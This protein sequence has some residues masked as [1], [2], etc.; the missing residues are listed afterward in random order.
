MREL[1]PWRGTPRLL[2]PAPVVARCRQLRQ[3]G[4]WRAA[5]AAAGFQVDIDLDDVAARYDVEAR[6]RIEDELAALAPD[7][8]RQYLTFEDLEY[9][10]NHVLSPSAT[11]YTWSWTEPALM[12]TNPRPPNGRRRPR[13]TVIGPSELPTHVTC[14][15]WMWRADAM[16]ERRDAYAVGAEWTTKDLQPHRRGELSRHDLHPLVHDA[17]YPDQVRSPVPARWEWPAVKVRC[18]QSWHDMRITGGRL[19]TLAHSEDEIAREFVLGGLTGPMLGCALVCHQWR[20]GEP[21]LPKL[22]RR[23]RH[24][25]FQHV[26][27]GHTDDVVDMLDAGF[28]LGV[29]DP[30]GASLLHHLYRLDEDRVWPRLQAAG[31]NVNARDYQDRTPLHYAADADAPDIMALLVNAGADPRLTDHRGQLAADTLATATTRRV[32]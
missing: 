13:L 6:R 27:Y 15:V 18:G 3:D 21:R 5:C 19:V 32:R 28:D 8:L 25:F 26:R 12:V 14:P 17:L 10:G 20:T 23:A 29:V 22:L 9:H 1:E 24:Q 11:P 7:L 30:A 31:L 2:T 4:D 16:A